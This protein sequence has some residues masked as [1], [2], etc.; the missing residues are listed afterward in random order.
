MI[1][2]PD[3]YFNEPGYEAM[4]KSDHGKA[5]SRRYDEE[6]QLN[7]MLYAI[8]P[9]LDTPCHAFANAIRYVIGSRL[10]GVSSPAMSGMACLTALCAMWCV[11]KP[12]LM[13]VNFP[14]IPPSIMPSWLHSSRPTLFLPM[15]LGM[16]SDLISP[17]FHGLSTNVRDKMYQ[18]CLPQPC[19]L[20]RPGLMWKRL[21]PISPI[22]VLYSSVW[23]SPGFPCPHKRHLGCPDTHADVFISNTQSP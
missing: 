8:Q 12:M 1:F 19:C 6:Q 17:E 4:R 14:L 7:T 5:A 13:C 20:S 2:V 18:V 22:K 15:P 9:A 11:L 10:P 21:P 23:S 3:P 16:I